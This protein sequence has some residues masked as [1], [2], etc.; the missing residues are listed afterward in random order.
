M[1]ALLTW[2][3]PFRR[4]SVAL[5][6]FLTAIKPLVCYRLI[7][8]IT[9]FYRQSDIAEYFQNYR[10]WFQDLEDFEIV[11]IIK[12]SRT[13]V[14]DYSPRQNSFSWFSKGL[15][16]SVLR[17]SSL[18]AIVKTFLKLRET[19]SLKRKQNSKG[20]S[21]KGTYDDIS[22]VIMFHAMRNS[23]YFDLYKNSKIRKDRKLWY[24][25]GQCDKI[26]P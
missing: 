17:L 19:K 10:N 8:F 9:K 13:V 23:I 15:F 5:Q 22:G 18:P 24:A 4:E 11:D 3:Y 7:L 25:N 6:M 12:Q 16:S 1:I 26:K 2:H 20:L 14:W 21:L